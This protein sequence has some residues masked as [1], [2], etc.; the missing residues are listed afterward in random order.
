[1]ARLAV[2]VVPRAA[3]SEI[4]GWMGD[5]LRVRVAAAPERGR[6]NAAL[7]DLLA[8]VLGLPRQQIRVASGQTATRKLIDIDGVDASEL[9]RRLPAREDR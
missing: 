9:R 3:R 1:V 4:V 5:S 2:K 6:A 7:I 8:D